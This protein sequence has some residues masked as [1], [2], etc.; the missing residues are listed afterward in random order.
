MTNLIWRSDV[1]DSDDGGLLLFA[2]LGLVLASLTRI[3]HLKPEQAEH[4]VD[5]LEDAAVALA[6]RP[7][8]EAGVP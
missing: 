8:E 3:P 5:R 2:S 1:S 4:L 6:K 7:R